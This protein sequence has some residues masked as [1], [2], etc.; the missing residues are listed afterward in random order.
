MIPPGIANFF[1][2]Y[3]EKLQ[4]LVMDENNYVFMNSVR[5][6]LGL[7]LIERIERNISLYSRREIAKLEMIIH[8]KN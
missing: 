7:D 6:L 1:I 5:V 8:L 3:G 2:F 4:D